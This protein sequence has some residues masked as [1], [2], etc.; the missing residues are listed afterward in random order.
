MGVGSGNVNHGIYDAKIADWVLFAG[1]DNVWHLQGSADKLTDTVKLKVALGSTTDVSF[2]G[3][4]DCL[5]I[6]ISGTLEVPHG[7][8]G[9]TSFT[10]NSLVISGTNTTSPLKSLASSTAGYY[11]VSG[12]SN[13]PHWIEP[14]SNVEIIRL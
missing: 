3:S 8:T 9:S 2:D 6:P 12:G 13:A 5:N 1:S 11:L 4:A 7:G 14:V 10:A